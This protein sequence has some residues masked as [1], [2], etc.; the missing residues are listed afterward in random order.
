MF[1]R[2]YIQICVTNT[3][4]ITQVM[5]LQ[6]AFTASY[7]VALSVERNKVLQYVQ[8]KL[9]QLGTLTI[10]DFFCQALSHALHCLYSTVMIVCSVTFPEYL[11]LF[12][13]KLSQ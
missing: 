9:N 7:T 8:Q 3:S 6:L 10:W 13:M 5:F 4:T 11:A 12:D 2:I 1:V